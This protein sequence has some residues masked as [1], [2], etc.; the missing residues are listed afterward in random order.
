MGAQT[1][2]VAQTG[3]AVGPLSA[4]QDTEGT[5]PTQLCWVRFTPLPTA[6]ADKGVTWD[7]VDTGPLGAQR[8]GRGLASV[9]DGLAAA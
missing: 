3:G 7:K 9:L 4:G 6:G 5:P 1:H 2:R 8:A